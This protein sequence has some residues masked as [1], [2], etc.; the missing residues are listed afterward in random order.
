ML[1]LVKSRGSHDRQRWNGL[2]RGCGWVC[3]FFRLLLWEEGRNNVV[4]VGLTAEH[5]HTLSSIWFL[6]NEHQTPLVKSLAHGGKQCLC[7][8]PPRPFIRRQTAERCCLVP[9]DGKL[10]SSPIPQ[11][12]PLS[13]SLP[14]GSLF[15]SP[16]RR[17]LAKA[18]ATVTEVKRCLVSFLPYSFLGS[19]PPV[20]SAIIVSSQIEREV[21]THQ[22]VTTEMYRSDLYNHH[23]NSHWAILTTLKLPLVW[24]VQAETLIQR[25]HWLWFQKW[26]LLKHKMPTQIISQ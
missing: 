19:P 11:P 26:L 22:L 15:L 13:T 9:S 18:Q 7:N 14:H 16:H 12:S 23:S 24:S 8:S 25:E 6:A 17:L 20:I 3:G 5:A 2:K 21:Q 1:G 10:K 4:L